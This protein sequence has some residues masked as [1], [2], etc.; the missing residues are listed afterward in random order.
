MRIRNLFEPASEIEL[1]IRN[2]FPESEYLIAM[3]TILKY[4]PAFPLEQ[5]TN[6]LHHTQG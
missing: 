1:W 4:V 6:T 3:F 2:D 5:A